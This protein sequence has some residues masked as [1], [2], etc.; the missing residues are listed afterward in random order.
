VISRDTPHDA[1]IIFP[2]PFITSF[3]SALFGLRSPQSELPGR[4]RKKVRKRKEKT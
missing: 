1:F 4:R 3:V 2:L